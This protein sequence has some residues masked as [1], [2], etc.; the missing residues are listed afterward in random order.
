MLNASL[1]GFHAVATVED[2]SVGGAGLRRAAPSPGASS[3]RV[4][5]ATTSPHPSLQGPGPP[6]SGRNAL[7]LF[8]L[9][10]GSAI[11]PF[12]VSIVGSEI[13]E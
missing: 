5:I 1:D 7:T 9:R 4:G 3:T 13:A 10:G 8:G 11:W 2:D 12:A 6:V